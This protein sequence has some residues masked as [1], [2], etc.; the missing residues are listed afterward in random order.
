MKYARLVRYLQ[1]G[2]GQG[3]RIKYVLK[4]KKEL[5]VYTSKIFMKLFPAITSLFN[6][7]PYRL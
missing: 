5:A 2:E 3:G 7:Q 4:V 6:K 1:G